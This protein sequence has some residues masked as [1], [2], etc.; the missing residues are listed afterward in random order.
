[1]AGDFG[2]K[3]QML[4][5]NAFAEAMRERK[6]VSSRKIRTFNL[7]EARQRRLHARPKASE[8]KICRHWLFDEIEAI[9]PLLI[10][11]RRYSRTKCRR[12]S[13]PVQSNRGTI[14]KWRT[15]GGSF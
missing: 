3:R 6:A 5:R 9:G 10:V 7:D 12:S 13:N 1:M 4:N 11:A 14:L 15:D 2:L 8:T